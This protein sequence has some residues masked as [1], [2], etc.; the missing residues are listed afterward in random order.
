MEKRLVWELFLL[1]AGIMY[2]V[3]ALCESVQ[4]VAFVV[5]FVT[6]AAQELVHTRR[7]KRKRSYWDRSNSC[8]KTDRA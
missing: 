3:M 1:A 4:S 2:V 5:V 8:R 6:L 7:E